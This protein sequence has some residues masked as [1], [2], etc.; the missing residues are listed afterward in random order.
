[1]IIVGPIKIFSDMHVPYPHL[2]PFYKTIGIYETG[3][4]QSDR[5]YF[6]PCEYHAG[7]KELHQFVVEGSPFILYV[8]RC[9]FHYLIISEKTAFISIGIKSTNADARSV[10]FKRTFSGTLMKHFAPTNTRWNV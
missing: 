9:L 8:D 7:S 10:K 6:G 4:S 1:M 3:L 5:F 2:S